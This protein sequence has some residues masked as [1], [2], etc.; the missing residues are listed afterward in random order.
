MP[1][2]HIIKNGTTPAVK[3][4]KYGMGDFYSLVY[5]YAIGEDK[6]D[7]TPYGN[8][9]EDMCSGESM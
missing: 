6:V 4:E 7:P 9:C 3:V 1:I 8:S 2:F 5:M